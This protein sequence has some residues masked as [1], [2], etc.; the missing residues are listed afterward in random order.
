MITSWTA[1]VHMELKIWAPVFW[2]GNLDTKERITLWPTPALS[3]K[4]L[5]SKLTLE[6]RQQ[7]LNTQVLR[8]SEKARWEK[9]ERKAHYQTAS[10]VLRELVDRD[11]GFIIILI[12]EKKKR[13]K[14]RRKV[15]WLIHL[16]CLSTKTVLN[17]FHFQGALLAEIQTAWSPTPAPPPPRPEHRDASKTQESSP[18]SCWIYSSTRLFGSDRFF[19][20]VCIAKG[21]TEFWIYSSS[22]HKGKQ[23]GERA[24]WSCH[25]CKSVITGLKF[26]STLKGLRWCERKRKKKPEGL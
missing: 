9:R 20:F 19:L 15:F 23:R 26:S 6:L 25:S 24:T 13:E 22:G 8:Q 12:L 14:E 3:H 4:A 16:S 10:E 11:L 21:G 18:P 17:I 5:T 7:L 2:A 1:L